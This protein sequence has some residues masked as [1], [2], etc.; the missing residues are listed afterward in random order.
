MKIWI[1]D[2]YFEI[3]IGTAWQMLKLYCCLRY[4]AWRSG[5]SV[6]ELIRKYD[7]YFNKR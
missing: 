4:T 5:I 3:T 6:D 1:H 7:W 2:Q